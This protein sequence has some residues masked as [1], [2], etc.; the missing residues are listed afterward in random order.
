MYGLLVSHVI[1][2]QVQRS[3]NLELLIRVKSTKSAYFM[4]YLKLRTLSKIAY[5]ITTTIPID[6][7]LTFTILVAFAAIFKL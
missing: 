2:C 3:P 6:K 5:T 1:Q 7:T 4:T